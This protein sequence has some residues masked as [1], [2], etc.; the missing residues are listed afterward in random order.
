M[1][2]EEYIILIPARK[3]SKRLKGKNK[4]M[5]L[6]KPLISH[7]IEYALNNFSKNQI[8]VNSDDIEIKDI[9]DSY[10]V[11]FYKRDDNL[12][13]DETSTNSVVFDFCKYLI[14]KKI[15]FKNVITLQPTNPIRS[16]G[17]LVDCIKKYENSNRNS[18]MTVSTLHKKFGAIRDENYH[19]MNYKIGQR[20]QDLDD[21]FYE[22]GLIYIS[23][24]HAI[25]NL[26]NYISE[27]VFP[28]L[29]SEIGSMIDIDF[30][31]DLKYA[32]LILKN[33]DYL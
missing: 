26:N 7:S 24:K 17:L 31:I 27:D 8:W 32:E 9:T 33:Q 19:P 29:T 12:A 16:E 5:L 18:L 10:E 2:T 3:N 13:L 14:S 21:L 23:S 28:Y 1:K 11:N 30:E 4:R 15:K 25:I 6:G 20:H 22:N